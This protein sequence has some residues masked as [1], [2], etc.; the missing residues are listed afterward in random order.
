MFTDPSGL[1]AFNAVLKPSNYKGQSWFSKH[2]DEPVEKFLG[3]NIFGLTPADHVKLLDGSLVPMSESG[4]R[5]SVSEQNF[6]AMFFC[7]T[8]LFSV[9]K[10]AKPSNSLSKLQKVK[11]QKTDF[12][13]KS[14]GDVV[15]G[16]MYRYSDSSTFETLSKTKES[17]ISYVSPKKF[18]TSEAAINGLQIDVINWKNDCC[19]RSSF[20]T[21]QVI[22]DIRVPYAGGDKLGPLKEPLTLF[23][24]E[25]GT[26]NVPQYKIDNAVNLNEITT[27]GGK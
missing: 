22:D 9:F 25:F 11:P 6:D 8:A 18:E 27:I 1:D 17:F 14:N 26:G 23:Y 4:E 24:P 7:A 2:I 21:I 5:F 13:V 16:T 10:L 20:D 15:P 3:R 19:V 12:Y